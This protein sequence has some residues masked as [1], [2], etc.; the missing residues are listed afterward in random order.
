MGASSLANLSRLRFF[1]HGEIHSTTSSHLIT[2]VNAFQLKVHLLLA[3][4]KSNTNNG[5]TLTLIY[6]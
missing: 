4:R 2:E 3:D 5:M 6:P 1:H